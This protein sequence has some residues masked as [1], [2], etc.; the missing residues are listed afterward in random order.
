MKQL[1]STAPEEKLKAVQELTTYCNDLTFATEFTDK[2]G[3]EVLINYVE[4]MEGGKLSDQIN[5]HL[6]PSFVD[7]MDHGLAQWDSLESAF[8]KKVAGLINNQSNNL[9]DARTLQAA[10]SILESLVLNSSKYVSV[11]REL[12]I[13][14]LAMHLQ[15]PSQAI[16]QNALAL[17][18]ALFLKADDGKRNAIAGTLNVRQIRNSIVNNII[19]G[20]LIINVFFRKLFTN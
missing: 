17:I 2:K 18:N 13:P 6:L 4:T 3:M 14:N 20:S 9:Q 16:Q 15:N 10:L 11:E 12:T 1:S 5:A 19:Q 7:L 8:I